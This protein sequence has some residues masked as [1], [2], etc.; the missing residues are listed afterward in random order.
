MSDAAPAPFHLTVLNPGGHDSEQHF[1]NGANAPGNGHH[2]ANFHA[3]AA[4]TRGSFHREVERATAEHAPILLLLRGDFKA[5]ERALVALKRRSLRVA[6]SL[7]ET[8]L[9]QIAHQLSDRAKLQRFLRVTEA[10]DACLGATPQAADL[11]RSVRR[12]SA[13]EF[14][15][16]PC[17]LSDPRW[18]FS[19]PLSERNGIF[20]GTREFFVPS[21]NHLAALLLAREISAKTG[22]PVTVWNHDRSKGAGLLDSLG[23]APSKLRVLQTYSGY[24]SYLREM[25]RHRI[26]LQLDRSAVPGQVAADALLARVPCLGGNGAIDQLA[27]GAPEELRDLAQLALRLLR[28][29]E[30]YLRFNSDAQLRAKERLSFEAVAPQ[31]RQFFASPN[32][33][34]APGAPLAQPARQPR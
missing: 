19:V 20:I 31:L 5:T 11:F 23:F 24:A 28:D 22:A 25:A 8:G 30:F 14:I 27:F 33:N 16:T 26:V 17:P 6:V 29:D 7:K 12:D 32:A 3:Y 21:R 10:A 2:P 9:H 18:D 1:T 13:A 34:T 15:P 4:C